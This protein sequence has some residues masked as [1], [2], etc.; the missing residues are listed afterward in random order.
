MGCQAIGEDMVLVPTFL[1]N[2]GLQRLLKQ[3][4]IATRACAHEVKEQIRSRHNT[5]LRSMPQ[6]ALSRN[7]YNQLARIVKVRNPS[8]DSWQV[9]RRASRRRLGGGG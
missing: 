5:L 2:E 9:G 1:G 8:L 4:M 3:G 7:Q 6:R